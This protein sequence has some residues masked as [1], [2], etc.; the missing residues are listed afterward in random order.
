[1]VS[2]WFFFMEREG[3][4][5]PFRNPHL[6][7]HRFWVTQ[8]DSPNLRL[9]YTYPDIRISGYPDVGDPDIFGAFKRVGSKFSAFKSVLPLRLAK[10]GPLFH[11]VAFWSR[12]KKFCFHSKNK[13]CAFPIFGLSCVKRWPTHVFIILTSRSFRTNSSFALSSQCRRLNLW[14]SWQ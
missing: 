1:M 8:S 7:R 11:V 3:T 14:E 12:F 2:T 4:R 9:C 6:R 10:T 5:L 13:L